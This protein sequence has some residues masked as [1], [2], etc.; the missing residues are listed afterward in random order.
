MTQ[1][2][3]SQVAPTP[4]PAA[5]PFARKGLF[6]P[7][8]WIS[9]LGFAAVCMVSFVVVKAIANGGLMPAPSVLVRYAC[10]GPAAP[11]SFY[12][13]HGDERVQIETASGRLDGILLNGKIAWSAAAAGAP[14]L[15][16]AVPTEITYDDAK[17]IRISGAGF[18]QLS[19][20]STES[21]AAAR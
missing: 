12:F 17:S 18:P 21:A 20:A 7:Y 16:M 10:T 1:R 14:S 5:D 15:G 9:A 4:V 8:V 19:C 11:F 2:D 6:F 13:L 3:A